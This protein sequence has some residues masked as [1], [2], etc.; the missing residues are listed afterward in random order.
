[1]REA[2]KSV[3]ISREFSF[4]AAHQLNWH[5]GKCYNLHG[6]T[7][8]LIVTV[9]GIPNKNGIVMD[10]GDL[11]KIVETYVINQLDHSYLNKTFKNPTAELMALKIFEEIKKHLTKK[12]KLV[13]LQLFES[14]TTWA[15]VKSK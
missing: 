7:Y 10:F 12:V 1:M 5:S 11:K 2:K 14:P 3:C 4:D 9:S 15:T 13:E 8:K 6:H